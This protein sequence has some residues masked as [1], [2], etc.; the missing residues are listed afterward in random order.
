MHIDHDNLTLATES[1]VE[2]KV[3]MPV[4]TG[5]IYL[6]IPTDRIR[7]KDYLAPA[8]LDKVAGRQSGYYPDYTVWM[9]GF[10]L[11]VVEA[12]APDVPAEVG[13]REASLYARHLNQAYPTNLNPCRFILATNGITLL[14]GYWDSE[15]EMTI[16]VTNLRLG[17]I[18]LDRL[19]QAYDARALEKYAMVCLQHVRSARAYYPYNLA[20][21]QALL[22]ARFPVNSF[23]AELSPVLRRYFSSSNDQNYREIIERAYVCSSEVTEYDRILEALLKERLVLHRGAIV[24]Q[25]E[26]TRHGEEHVAHAIDQFDEDRPPGGQLQIIQGAVGSGKSLFTRRYKELVQSTSVSIRTRWAFVDF[27]ASPPDLAHAERWLCKTFAESFQAENSTLDLFSNKAL[28]GVFSRNI[29]RRKPIYDGLELVSP[30]QAAVV[31]AN[32]LAN[33]QDDPQEMARGIADYVLGSR[34]E[35][36]I[37]V[38]DNVDRLD[39]N[40]QL[41]AFQLALWFMRQTNCFVILQM[42]DETYERYKNKPPLDTF[43][44]GITF[45]ISPPRF[46]D[47]VKRRLELSCE[48]LA[49]HP[50]ME[51]TQTYTIESGV[52]VS[53]PKSALEEFLRELYVEL[54]DRKRNISRVLEAVAGWDVRRALEMFVSIITSGHLSETAITSTVLGGRGVP[55][56][57]QNIL[58]IL[59]RTEYRFFSDHSG[60]ISN[61]FNFDPDWQKPDNFLL[62]E[63]LYYLGRNRKRRGQIGLEGYFTCRHVAD[64]LQRQGY[65]PEDALAALNTLLRHQLI[66]ADHMNFRS[67]DDSVRIL[68]SGF[69]HVRFIVARMEYLYGVIA[70][71]PILER[72]VAER[73]A[74]FVKNENMRGRIPAYQKLRAVELFYDYLLRQR[75]ANRTPFS[76]SEDTGSAY[77]LKHVAGAIE[78]YK[79]VHAASSPGPDVLDSDM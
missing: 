39:L 13:Y 77:V 56:T 38:M 50:E 43:R 33:W 27:N 22:H 51:R 62:I 49:A 57:E 17:S 75:N 66:S 61:I 7:T 19:R 1:D 71:T 36:L 58:R 60:F 37:A 10:P 28:R 69:M 79:N 24:Q 40:N 78:H 35:A 48:Y 44:T 70:T 42:R 18:D 8:V 4:L 59:M 73:L 53:Y 9:R 41:H 26:P 23:A 25:L 12:K 46:T 32:D 63:A 45:H 54:F 52:R 76:L 30:E 14:A 72:D 31:K 16:D 47:V 74:E 64:E 67:L 15:P 68:A 2:Q 34:H 21:G 3:I 55:I 29:Q 6:E 20:G 5:G 65:V 11:L